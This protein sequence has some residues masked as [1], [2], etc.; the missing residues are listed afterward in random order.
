MT[1]KRKAIVIGDY[2]K[3]EYHPLK[4]PDKE[5]TGILSDFDVAFTED[6]DRFKEENL[7]GYDLCISFTDRWKAKMTD[8]QTAGL[9]AYVCRGGG[10]LIIHN[11]I[12]IQ[13]RYELAQLAGGKFTQHPEQK[14]LNYSPVA[15][16]HVIT[17][18]AGS[19]SAKEEP[20]QFA[21]DNLA[22][23]TILLEYESE[24]KR[25]P[26]A[27]AHSYGSG[28]VVYL[29]P[30]HNIETFLDPTYRRIILRSALWALGLL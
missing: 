5:L 27:W 25:W 2:T 26:A 14:V 12:S 10:L 18:G 21:L 23:T 19:F 24:G 28:R 7:C 3:V 13:T 4:G 11:G 30:G 1:E 16:G 6:Y 20:Y 9:L 15:S 29:S 8:E 17:E 22:E